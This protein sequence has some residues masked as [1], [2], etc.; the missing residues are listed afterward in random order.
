MHSAELVPKAL[1]TIGLLPTAEYSLPSVLKHIMEPLRLAKTAGSGMHQDT[2]AA[3][4]ALVRGAFQHAELR[5]Q[6][7]FR[8]K[9][10]SSTSFVDSSLRARTVFDDKVARL[11][12]VARLMRDFKETVNSISP[13]KTP[14]DKGTPK[15]R[16]AKRRLADS[17]GDDVEEPG[18]RRIIE[19]GSDG[20]LFSFSAQGDTYSRKAIQ[21]GLIEKGNK[22][23]C[24]LY[25]VANGPPPLKERWCRCGKTSWKHKT[26]LSSAEQKKHCVI[27]ETQG[28]SSEGK[29]K[30][31]KRPRKGFQRRSAGASQ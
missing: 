14:G 4:A 3:A 21:A 7:A 31:D 27:V 15:L 2:A 1:W 5:I 16:S 28:P 18:S 22:G 30:A 17:A 12:D 24:E 9:T 20:D 13:A 26:T 10:E 11:H 19:R 8:G 29:D 23:G 6:T 25:A